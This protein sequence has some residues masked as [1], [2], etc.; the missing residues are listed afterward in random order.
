LPSGAFAVASLDV[1]SSYNETHL[2]EFQLKVSPNRSQLK[3]S[4]IGHGNREVGRKTSSRR[5]KIKRA[6]RVI[7]AVITIGD[8]L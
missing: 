1:R 8:L 3:I 7:E 5:V 6:L 2:K 4:G